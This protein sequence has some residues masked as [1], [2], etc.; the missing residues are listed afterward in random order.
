VLALAAGR[1]TRRYLLPVGALLAVLVVAALALVP[2]LREAAEERKN[3]QRPLFDRQN[4]NAAALR[5]VS[6]KPLWGHGWDRF[7]EESKPYYRQS[8]DY[9]LTIVK[10]LH[11]L[12]LS[13]AVELGLIGAL[14]WAAAV[15]YAI[16]GAILRRGPPELMAWKVG[17]VAVAAGLLV[18]WA[19]APSGFLMPTLLMWTWAGLA[20]AGRD[21]PGATRA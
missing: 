6:D 16:G 5:M 14:L 12:Y 21:E 4:S 19:A 10:D 13:H 1:S 17:L 15:A 7:E 8:H 20:W 18:S 2:N 3:D 11:N 9:P